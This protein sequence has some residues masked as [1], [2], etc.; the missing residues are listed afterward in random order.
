[1]FAAEMLKGKALRTAEDN[2]RNMGIHIFSKVHFTPLHFHQV[3]V[4]DKQRNPKRIYAFTNTGKCLLFI[5]I[6]T[7]SLF[8]F[9]FMPFWLQKPS[10]KLFFWVGGGGILS[11]PAPKCITNQ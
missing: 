10:Q 11:L 9:C 5:I 6:I 7:L 8:T 1:M 3:P 2:V 4:F